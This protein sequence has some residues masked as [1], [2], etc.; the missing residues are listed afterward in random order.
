M[1]SSWVH[2]TRLRGHFGSPSA[3]GSAGVETPLVRPPRHS[4]LARLGAT[5]GQPGLAHGVLRGFLG[6]NGFKVAAKAYPKSA[7]PRHPGPGLAHFPHPDRERN[8]CPF[9]PHLQQPT[10]NYRLPTADCQNRAGPG[11]G[12]GTRCSILPVFPPTQGG[13]YGKVVRR[14]PAIAFGLVDGGVDDVEVARV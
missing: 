5:G 3:P 12:H 9:S 6:L 8:L 13:S 4:R 7:C 14:I 2:A 1:F 11:R 10:T